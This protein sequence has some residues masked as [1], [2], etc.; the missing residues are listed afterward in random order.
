MF[1]APLIAES[2]QRLKLEPGTNL[3]DA[4]SALNSRKVRPVRW[5]SQVSHGGIETQPVAAPALVQ[6][7]K[8]LR[9]GG[10]EHLPA[11]LKLVI[12]I[13]REVEGFA[14]AQI[15]ARVPE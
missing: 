9:V 3:H 12:F 15:Q 6:R 5:R 11:D 7:A 8:A 14:Q 1:Y 4:R 10:V 2:V 13:P